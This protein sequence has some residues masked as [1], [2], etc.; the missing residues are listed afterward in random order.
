[1]NNNSTIF[2]RILLIIE[3]KG[4]KNVAELAAKLGYDK[5]Q[6]IYRLKQ[7]EDSKPSYDIIYDLTIK[8]EDLNVRWFI[9][10]EGEPFTEG[11]IKNA[12]KEPLINYPLEVQQLKDKVN[13]LE[14]EKKSILLALREFGVGLA[15]TPEKPVK[16][17]QKKSS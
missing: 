1:L 11:Y 17:K 9:T 14:I 5:P 4:I 3:K 12:I 15:N 16:G 2:D 10:G 6:K 8:F 13:E 7:E